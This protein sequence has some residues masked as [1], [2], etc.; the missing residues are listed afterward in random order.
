M[1]RKLKIGD[2]LHCSNGK[3]YIVCKGEKGFPLSIISEDGKLIDYTYN[4]LLFGDNIRLYIGD[5][6]I[7]TMVINITWN[8]PFI[9]SES[10]RKDVFNRVV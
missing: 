10:R 5:P 3:T 2:R 8:K 9:L 7:D 6:V 4:E 1:I